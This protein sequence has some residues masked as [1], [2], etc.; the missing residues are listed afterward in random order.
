MKR[1]FPLIVI[2]TMLLFVPTTASFGE[3]I[4]VPIDLN[5]M[6]TEELLALAN[7]LSAVLANRGYSFAVGSSDIT[8]EK[9]ELPKTPTEENTA[10]EEIQSSSEGATELSDESYIEDLSAA[11]CA[12]W[13]IPDQDISVL[14]DKQRIEYYTMLVNS[15]FAFL[16]KYNDYKFTDAR[17]GEYAQGYISALQAQYIAIT[18]YFGKD[19]NLYDEYWGSGYR[20]RARYIYLINKSYGLNIPDQHTGIL[21]DMAELGIFNNIRIPSESAIQAELSALELD[22]SSEGS[23]KY[24]YILPFNLTNTSSNELSSLSVEVNFINEK[25]VIIDSGYLISYENI[26]PGKAQS[27]QK[28]S[29][30]SHFTHISYSYSFNVN[31]G[32]YSD[33]IKGTVVPNIQYSWDGTVRKN[34]ELASGQPAFTIENLRSGWEM[35]SSWSKALYVP[36][37]KF[38]IRNTG[39]G[40]ADQITVRCLFTNSGTKEIW[41]EETTYVVGS[42]DTA[43]K[44]GYSRK[45]FVYSSVGYKTEIISTPELSVDI[46]INERLMDT[47]IIR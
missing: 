15:E 17:L 24:L 19:E 14:S 30:D 25:D 2:I 11:L 31:T 28:V 7:Q 12:R 1:I 36:A 38:D 43:L 35:E 27:T 18:E 10:D 39:T 45:A 20:T 9:A 3:S 26:A 22:F 46:F 6:D 40:D 5:A 8:E 4:K 42:S 44:V 37:V 47:I 32:T 23:N 16:K 34:G 13:E 33:T 29:I 41:D 21:K